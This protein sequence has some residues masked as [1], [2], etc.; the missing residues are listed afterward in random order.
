MVIEE[1]VIF[2]GE[3]RLNKSVRHFVDSQRDT[4]FL[5]ELGNQIPLR[6]VDAHRNLELPIRNLVYGWKRGGQ[7][8]G[9]QC[10]RDDACCK[11]AK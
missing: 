5:A 10:E 9:H 3:D 2:S 4:L 7:Y 1:R 6:G 8:G 11:D